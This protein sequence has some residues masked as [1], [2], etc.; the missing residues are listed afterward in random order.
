MSKIT[1][2][3]AIENTHPMYTGRA[4]ITVH[5]LC[6][7][8]VL[9]FTDMTPV[10]ALISAVILDPT[11]GNNLYHPALLTDPKHRAKAARRITVGRH[12]IGLGDYAVYTK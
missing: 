12:S 2:H 4:T 3:D 11:P 9:T 6:C 7:D 5:K 8:E 10:D 1:K